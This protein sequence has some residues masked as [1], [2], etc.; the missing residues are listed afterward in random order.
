MGLKRYLL[1]HRAKG[2]TRTFVS[3]EKLGNR[4]SL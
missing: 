3:G 2:N 4:R 1:H